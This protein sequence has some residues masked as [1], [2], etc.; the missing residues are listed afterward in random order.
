MPLLTFMCCTLTSTSIANGFSRAMPM[1]ERTKIF[2][3]HIYTSPNGKVSFRY[4]M[5]AP[6]IEQGQ[7]YALILVL[8]SRSGYAYGAYKL[9]EQIRNQG[10]PAF[11][12]VPMMDET[13]NQWINDTY[14]KADPKHPMPIDHAAILVRSMIKNLPIN[15]SR[16]Y[17]T[18]YSM[19]GIGTFA[20]LKR[21]PNLFAAGIAI[22]GGWPSGD[23]KAFVHKPLWA[24]HGT[25]DKIIPASQTRNIIEEVR[26][27]GG[28]PRYTE[29]AGIGHDSWLLAYEEPDLWTWLFS[30]ALPTS[31]ETTPEAAP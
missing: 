23:A 24:F 17:V 1:A 26:K 11:V 3:H 19:G 9:A 6:E 8:H 14:R 28:S 13:V 2:Q 16:V 15:P 21:F 18:G 27:E 25:D 12:I 5:M 29:Y 20:A 22:C 7:E 31:K 30:H 4:Y 10:M